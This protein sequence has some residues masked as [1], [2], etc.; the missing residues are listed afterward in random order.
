[1]KEVIDK[2]IKNNKT[3]ATME[4]CTGGALANEITNVADASKVFKFSAI[5][6]CNEFKVKMGVDNKIISKYTVYSIEVAKEMSKVISDFTNCDY[7]IG[8]TG[9]LKKADENNPVDNDNLVYI[10]IYDK[11]KNFYYTM[12][13]EVLDLPRSENKKY[14]VNKIVTLLKTIV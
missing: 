14:V 5:T 2:L 10:S 7:G 11:N 6:Y 4:S 13:I 3:I 12:S 9:Q 8:I 1:M